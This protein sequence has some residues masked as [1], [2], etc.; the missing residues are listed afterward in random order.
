MPKRPAYHIKV[1]VEIQ[2]Q[3]V[4]VSIMPHWA[5]SNLQLCRLPPPQDTAAWLTKQGHFDEVRALGSLVLQ[6]PYAFHLYLK[7]LRRLRL[8]NLKKRWGS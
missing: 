8:F 4:K 6:A 7:R 1:F 5:G 2:P 3:V